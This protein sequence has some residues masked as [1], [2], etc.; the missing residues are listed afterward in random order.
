MRESANNL[1]DL[2]LL[3]YRND[4]FAIFNNFKFIKDFKFFCT[5]IAISLYFILN[6]NQ[7]LQ[8]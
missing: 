4:K 3:K 1:R 8:M 5:K 7:K 6:N 2:S